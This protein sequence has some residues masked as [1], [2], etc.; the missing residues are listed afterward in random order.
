MELIELKGNPADG[1]GGEL[2]NVESLGQTCFDGADNNNDG[3]TDCDDSDYVKRKQ[4]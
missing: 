3:L 4:C 1:G 2:I